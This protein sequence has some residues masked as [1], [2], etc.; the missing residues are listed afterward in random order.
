MSENETKLKILSVATELFSRHG[1]E[2]ASIREIAREAGVNL[3]A[4]NYH[5]QNKLNLYYKVMDS[6]CE[7]MEK[8][9]AELAHDEPSVE[10][11]TQRIFD[12]FI[13]RRH[14]MMNSFKIILTET[15]TPEVIEQLPE[16]HIGPPGG[17]VLLAAIERQIGDKATVEAKIW[18]TKSIFSQITNLSLI[19]S[20]TWIRQHCGN[21]ELFE[22]TYQKKTFKHLVKSFLDHIQSE[23]WEKIESV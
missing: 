14:E 1:Y 5:F 9:I 2:G 11:L 17:E 23:E 12:Y 21:I 10:T 19:V 6:N 13:E 20:S 22:P 16:G 4:V 8:D 15:D 3:A 7:R 18:A